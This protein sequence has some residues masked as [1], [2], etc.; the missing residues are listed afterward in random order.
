MVV[1]A[2]EA[3]LNEI[4]NASRDNFTEQQ[5]VELVEGRT[6]D[7]YLKLVKSLSG[8][9]H[10][11]FK[12]LL[13]VRNE[14]VHS[15]PYTQ[16]ISIGN[17]VPARLSKLEE[18]GLLISTSRQEDFHFSQKLGSYALGYWACHTVHVAANTLSG[19][20]NPL[21]SMIGNFAFYQEATAQADLASYD[22]RFGL[23]LT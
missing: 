19:N 12:L 2:F 4:I 18:K 10:S 20:Q 9:V 16:L 15:L 1:M 23:T 6:Y 13:D 21:S 7:K 5:I 11:D 3:W 8:K 22:Q 17:T 14:I